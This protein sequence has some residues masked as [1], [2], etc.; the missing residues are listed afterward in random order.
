MRDAG[1]VRV[2]LDA[3]AVQVALGAGAVQVALGAVR[4]WGH[5]GVRQDL[6]GVVRGDGHLA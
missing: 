5:G 4:V 3:G 6:D 2:A 1:V